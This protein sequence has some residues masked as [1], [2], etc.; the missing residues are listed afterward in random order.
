MGAGASAELPF[1][2]QEAALAAGKTQQEID[3]WLKAAA[4]VA[5]S[6]AWRF[7]LCS[8]RITSMAHP[9]PPPRPS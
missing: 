1:E 7:S 6:A 4:D 2:S 8:P 5:V 3:E 9:L